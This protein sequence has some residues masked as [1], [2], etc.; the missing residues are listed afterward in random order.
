MKSLIIL[1][2]SVFLFTNCTEA[3]TYFGNSVTEKGIE[4][5]TGH[6]VRNFDLGLQY[7]FSPTKSYGCVSGTLGKRITFYAGENGED[8]ETHNFAITPSIGIAQH[9]ATVV[10][11]Y[12]SSKSSVEEIQRKINYTTMVY[13]IE[14][15]LSSRVGHRLKYTLSYSYVDGQK[16][17]SIGWKGYIKKRS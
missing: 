2:L 8:E 17:F 16:F 11:Y 12:V 9:F 14:A 1:T 6:V 7:R 13:K 10:D 15:Q 4:I 3:Q 5:N